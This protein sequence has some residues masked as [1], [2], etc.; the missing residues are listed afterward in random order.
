VFF[1]L[2]GNVISQTVVDRR[3]D[4]EVN[5]ES[6][7][8]VLNRFSTEFGLN[9]T[10]NASDPQLDKKISFNAKNKKISTLLLATL[11]QVG[12]SYEEV[13]N[14]LVILKEPDETRVSEMAADS[15]KIRSIDEQPVQSQEVK[16]IAVEVPVTVY[17]TVTMYDTIIRTETQLIRDTVVIEK[18]VE[19]NGVRSG[20]FSGARKG[21][22][23]EAD[24]KKGWALDLYYAQIL[25]GYQTLSTG[26]LTPELEKVKNSE[27]IS[28]RN[29][30]LG[31]AV[32]YNIQNFSLSLGANLT[33]FNHRFTYTE[34]TSSGGYNDVDTLDIFYTILQ[35]DTSW[36][37]VTD[38]TYIPLDETEEN[39]EIRNRTGLIEFNL[40]AAYTFTIS[41]YI[42][43]F[44]KAGFDAGIPVWLSGRSILDEPGY[45][46]APLDNNTVSNVFY[47]YR[48]GLGVKIQLSSWF[49]LYVDTYYK[50]FIN[51]T[52]INYPLD[53][54]LH[55][56][57]IRVG[58]LY[59]L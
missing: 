45:P 39:Y 25:S 57:G 20:P 51:N 19:R 5:N 33:S 40:S 44:A 46:T 14:H 32:Q 38:T 56:L 47:G 29:L 15:L 21:L 43:L 17:D 6:L 12:Y 9:L 48:A 49:D 11:Y 31:M 24:R 4:F 37:Y 1:V 2:T 54:R 23:Y 41:E 42:S 36:I 3:V 22:V 7:R 30:S 53:R 26:D 34:V 59:Y 10:Y 18:V 52:R 55:G 27:A 8:E 50:R 35:G 28:F 13:G 58:L 16:L